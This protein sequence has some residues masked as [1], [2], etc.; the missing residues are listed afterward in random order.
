M[1]PPTNQADIALPDTA[2]MPVA[3]NPPAENFLRLFGEKFDKAELWAIRADEHYVEIKTKAG[4]YRL[5]RGRM[6][7]AEKALPADLGM[8]V[9]RSHWVA[10]Q[11]LKTLEQGRDRWQLSLH[12]GTEVPVARGRREQT[13]EWASR[14][15]GD[16]LD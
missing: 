14:V 6:S 8:R 10:T 3:K 5:L 2:T 13:K 11:A 12:C 9:H 1:P 4:E 7:E 15:L 16:H